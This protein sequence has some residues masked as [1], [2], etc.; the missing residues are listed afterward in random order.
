MGRMI[1]G[2]VGCGKTALAFGAIALAAGEGFQSALMAPT[3][4]LARQH[5]ENAKK[6][7]EPM[8]IPCGLLIGGMRTKER[9][10]ALEKIASGEWKAVIGTHALISE[11]VEYCNLGLVVTDEQHRFGVRQRRLLSKKAVS[12]E[13]APNELVMS[14]TP[15][16]RTLAL[17]LYGDLD[18]SVVDELPPGRT[19]VK[20]RIVPEEKRDGL[21]RGLPAE[22]GAGGT[23]LSGVYAGQ[24]S[25]IS[26]RAS[27]LC[28]PGL[29]Q[30][31]SSLV[32]VSPP[33]GSDGSD[34]GV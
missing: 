19:P 3:E 24:R 26:D 12:E 28:I 5:L 1:Q 15:I 9:R 17:V 6:L 27:C 13:F 30:A 7:L 10:E 18:L 4:I 33:D 22:V 31:V 14:A 8:G 2:D 23:V 34:G 16:P 20:T 25:C 11:G 21:Y 29:Y 32:F